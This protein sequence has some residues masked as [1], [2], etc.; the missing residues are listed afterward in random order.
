[1]VKP[2]AATMAYGTV[3]FLATLAA[4]LWGETHGVKTDVLWI[5]SVPVV[6]GLFLG[7][8]ISGAKKA[9]EQA[10]AQTNGLLDGRVKAAVAAALADRDAARTRQAQGDIGSVTRPSEESPASRP[11]G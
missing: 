3:I 8:S 7:E 2:N 4:W 9:A 6:G 11:E 5:V 10:A 1:M